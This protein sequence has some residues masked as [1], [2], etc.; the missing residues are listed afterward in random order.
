MPSLSIGG[1]LLE[2][3]HASI[4]QPFWQKYGAVAHYDFTDSSKLIEGATSTDV[5]GWK[6]STLNN[7]NLSQPTASA[8]PTFTQPNGPLVFGGSGYL[9]SNLTSLSGVFT[10]V[11]RITS[12]SFNTQRIL[13]NK[14]TFTNAGFGIVLVSGTDIIVR[15]DGASPQTQIALGN[16]VGSDMTIG[17]VYDN[18]NVEV[19]KDGIYQGS[20]T[21][22]DASANLSGVTV[23]SYTNGTNNFIGDM[24]AIQAYP[25]ALNA[26]QIANITAELNS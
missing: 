3:L 2:G 9:E 17:V 15:G 11:F 14:S 13:T 20:G 26:T 6:D 7:Y 24:H 4:I 21:I 19:Y 1:P 10:V 8:Q 12:N 16:F 25:T 18:S 23:G 22:T 5:E